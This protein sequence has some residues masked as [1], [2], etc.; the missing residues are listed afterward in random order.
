MIAILSL[1]IIAWWQRD[2]AREQRNVAKERMYNANYNLAKVFEEKALNAQEDARKENSV[3]GFKHAF[4]YTNAGLQQEIKPEA[5]PFKLMSL[6]KLLD[7]KDIKSAFAQRCFSPVMSVGSSVNVVV[8]S[9]DDKYLACSF[10]K[11][12]H[13]WDVSTRMLLRE[14]K[15]HSHS[16][17]SVAFSPDGKYLATGLDLSFT[18]NY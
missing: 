3:E 18:L 2:V 10:D 5:Q 17:N 16:V 1:A 8:F 6:G 15:G 14:M 4:L 11:V 9:P 13:L 12:V 7:T